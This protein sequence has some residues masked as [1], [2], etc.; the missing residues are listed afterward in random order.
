M[1]VGREPPSPVPDYQAIR[2]LH[3]RTLHDM[4]DGFAGALN[5]KASAGAER[6]TAEAGEASGERGARSKCRPF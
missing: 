4:A 2:E 1:K 3:A 5:D 6:R